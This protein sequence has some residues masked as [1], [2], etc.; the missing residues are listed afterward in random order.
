MLQL[1]VKGGAN[2]PTG[3]DDPWQ[4]QRRTFLVCNSAEGDGCW[5]AHALGAGDNPLIAMQMA[6]DELGTKLECAVLSSDQVCSLGVH[7]VGL[8]NPFPPY[9]SRLMTTCLAKVQ[10]G[11][12]AEVPRKTPGLLLTSLRLKKARESREEVNGGRFCSPCCPQVLSAVSSCR[13]FAVPS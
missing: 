7:M 12:V 8:S 11:G 13:F 5:G 2:D 6:D 4:A 1:D 9:G 3:E 10:T